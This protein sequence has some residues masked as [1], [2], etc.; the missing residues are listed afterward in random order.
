M[1][2]TDNLAEVGIKGQQKIKVAKVLLFYLAAAGIGKIGIVDSD[3]ID[4]CNLN[5]QVLHRNG[6]IGRA[7]A[8]SAR[9]ALKNLNPD[10]EVLA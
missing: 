10:I 2:K 1:S 8:E 9:L 4:L 5:R 7:K 6:D 3:A